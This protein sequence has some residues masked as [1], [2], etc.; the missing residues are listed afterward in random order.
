V[1]SSSPV[2]ASSAA[3]LILGASVVAAPHSPLPTTMRLVATAYCDKGPTKSGVRTQMGIVAADPRVLPLGTVLRIVAPHQSYEGI[4][5]V[6][7]TGTAVKGRTLDIFMPSC[8]RAVRFGRR[9]VSVRIL[10]SPKP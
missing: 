6:M 8:A 3:W 7:D 9:R 2:V 5:T 10:H 1:L 4:Y